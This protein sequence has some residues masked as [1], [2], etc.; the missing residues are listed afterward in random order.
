MIRVYYLDSL[1]W[2]DYIGHRIN[3]AHARGEYPTTAAA[4][5]SAFRAIEQAMVEEHPLDVEIVE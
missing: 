2:Y 4:L 3:W 1:R 5:G